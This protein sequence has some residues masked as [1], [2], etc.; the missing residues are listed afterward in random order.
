MIKKSKL[1]F[2][3]VVC[4]FLGLAN[5]NTLKAATTNLSVCDLGCDYTTLAGAL[6][7]P[8]LDG[9]GLIDTVNLTTDYIFDFSNETT[10]GADLVLEVPAGVT[11]SCTAGADTFGDKNE[12]EIEISA[13]TNFTLQDCSTENTKMGLSGANINLLN[14]TFSSDTESW[15]TLTAVDGYEISGNT[16]IQRLQ[17]QGADNGLIEDNDIECRYT[18]CVN[19]VTNGA[20]DYND[21]P[22]IDANICNNVLINNNN[23]TNYATGNIGDWVLVNGGK[24]I[25]FTNNTISSAVTMDDVYMTLVTVQNA[26]AEFT[27]NYIIGPEKTFGATQDTWPF[28]IRVDEYDVDVLYE[29]NTVYIKD[30]ACIGLYD[31]GGKPNIPIDI[32]ANYNLCFQDVSVANSTGISLQYDIGSSDITITDSFN[33]FYGFSDLI[34]DSTGTI[35]GLNVNTVTKNPLLRTDNVDTTDD[36]YPSPFSNYL[37]ADG[38]QDIGAYSAVRRSTIN[39]DLAGP[40]DYS[41]IDA[42]SFTDIVDAIRSG[43]DINFAAG[44][45]DPL[46]LSFS[47]TDITISGEGDSTI[48]DAGGSGSALSLQNISDAS[49]SNFQ[50]K[51]SASL[52]TTTYSIDHA[53]YTDGVNTYDESANLGVPANSALI[54]TGPPVANTCNDSV[55]YDADDFDIT[56]ITDLT[57]SNWNLGLVNYFAGFARFT[58]LVPNDYVSSAAELLG[59]SDPGNITVE[60][61]LNDIYTVDNGIYTYNSDAVLGAGLSVKPGDTDP[62]AITRTITIEESGGLLL[63]NSSG[64]T[65]TNITATDNDYNLLIKGTS[66]SNIL[67]DST[68]SNSGNSD[69]SIIGTGNNIFE[70]VSF[71]RS[72]SNITGSG[73]LTVKYSAKFKTVDKNNELLSGA[74]ANFSSANLVDTVSL[75]TDA[76]GLTTYSSPLTAY[77]VDSTSILETA[78][79]YNP[80]TLDVSLDKYND[81]SLTINLNT[82][83]QLVPITMTKKSS[84]GSGSTLS[85]QINNLIDMG[86][87][88]EAQK[89]INQY[90]NANLNQVQNSPVCQLVN[91]LITAGVINDD[92]S[93]IARTVTGCNTPDQ[94]IVSLPAFVFNRD[95]EVGMTGE[96]VRQLQIFLN[97][98]GYVLAETGP[99]SIGNETNRFGAL[100][101][102]SLIRYQDA[103]FES[104]LKPLNLKKGTGYFGVSTRK[105]INNFLKH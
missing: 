30:G 25:Q 74:L 59:C 19:V 85:G 92:K 78:G 51:G 15:I 103:N 95:L 57:S 58:V 12:A 62:P 45:Y 41:N 33:G 18:G 43:D 52:S 97:N 27:S 34:T 84:G 17:L 16:G 81:N 9:D 31:S 68:L 10:A 55:F 26:Q 65:F 94:T 49:F 22:G 37:D 6:V 96:D 63:N 39:I 66:A 48:F 13:S 72:S 8:G 73:D 80:Y 93:V 53:Q 24:N 36:Y 1:L 50:V 75:S 2:V 101:K 70:D 29:H 47:A 60:H 56:S 44:T 42:I 14:N 71:D 90:P 89:L 87:I 54:L 79:G 91:I 69:V 46:E 99:G 88:N 61:F 100:T 3:I 7:D 5:V 38:T 21:L 83:Y 104:I 102:V 77:I 32:T 98:N 40:V 28:N 82:P 20:P 11:I 4:I 64:N 67:K 105:Y 76:T 35:T 86:K 23:I